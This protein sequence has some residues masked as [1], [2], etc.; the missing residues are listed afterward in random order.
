MASSPRPEETRAALEALSAVLTM[1]TRAEP[2]LRAVL[3]AHPHWDN[4]ARSR[5]ARMVNGPACL[6]ARLAYRGGSDAPAA[7][8]AAYLVEEMALPPGAAAEAAGVEAA[9]L[10]RAF[11]DARPWPA[12]PV[13]RLAAERSLPPWLAARWV[14][15]LGAAE[16]D[17]LA[18]A[19]NR[20]GPLTLRV[21]TLKTTR[22]D[23]AVRLA[24][25]GWRV[26]PTRASTWGLT[27][28]GPVN[29]TGN[30][31]WRDGCFEVQDEASQLAALWTGARPG[32]VV[33][34]ACAGSG[35]KTLALAAMMEDRGELWVTD[36]D[37]ARLADLRGRTRRLG[38]RCV[39][40]TAVD[41]PPA[42]ADVVLVDA[43]CS[44]TGALRRGPDA[45]WWL[46]ETA[47]TRLPTLQ[48]AILSRAARCVRPG[49]RLMYVTCS[50]LR[51][52]N[53]DVVARFLGE[54]RDFRAAPLYAGGPAART[55]LPHRDGT[56]GFHLAALVRVGP[57]AAS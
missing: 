34:D 17:A 3:R 52:E 43:P 28:A 46:D 8:L 31:A 44:S 30:A 1:Q 2:A 56:D 24:A 21:N 9:V 27:V 36:A 33:L 11:G 40:E 49:G 7:V 14:A 50:L 39:R 15:E 38:L 53:E 41:A 45:R 4:A 5:V 6:R 57:P 18:A 54:H 35:G 22:A 20:P 25:G 47:V 26:E 29:V 19:L 55:L 13:E 37:P 48:A 42:A 12:D 32:D 51:A 23:L 16:A 10:E